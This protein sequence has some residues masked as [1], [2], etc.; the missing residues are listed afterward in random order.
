MKFNKTIDDA[1]PHAATR[2]LLNGCKAQAY[3]R[4]AQA[5]DAL[6]ALAPTLAS[7]RVGAVHFDVLVDVLTASLAGAY[8]AGKESVLKA[9]VPVA[10]AC[11]KR[12]DGKERDMVGWLN[13]WLRESTRR[14][15][16]ALAYSRLALSSAGDFFDQAAP[17]LAAMERKDAL[18]RLDI[19]AVVNTSLE[20]LRDLIGDGWS[21]AAA[22]HVQDD[23]TEEKTVISSSSS[24]SFLNIIPLF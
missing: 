6:A 20:K 5:F 19:A 9:C 24:S 4:R 12:S 23:S 22:D 7:Q 13:R 2:A 8:W 1:I 11:V 18:A 16:D 10:L 21:A 17:V 14:D 15:D 3:S